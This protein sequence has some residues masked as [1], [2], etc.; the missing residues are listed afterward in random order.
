MGFTQ[1]QLA[2]MAQ[3][4]L[5]SRSLDALIFLAHSSLKT[6]IL[7]SMCSLGLDHTLC[8]CACDLSH[9]SV[10]YEYIYIELNTYDLKS[11]YSFF[12]FASKGHERD[13]D[14]RDWE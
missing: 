5:L 8:V 9:L 12:H 1:P 3:R 10:L 14:G 7:V 6:V 13:I 4:C 11:L 2:L